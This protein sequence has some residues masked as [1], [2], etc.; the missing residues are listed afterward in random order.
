M[1]DV[2]NRKEERVAKLRASLS[3][4]YKDRELPDFKSAWDT[5]SAVSVVIN[6]VISGKGPTQLV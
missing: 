5:A 2:M 4:R 3:E 6:M 1:R